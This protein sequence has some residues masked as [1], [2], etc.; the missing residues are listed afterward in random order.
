MAPRYGNHHRGGVLSLASLSES[1]LAWIAVVIGAVSIY[2]YFKKRRPQGGQ[3]NAPRDGQGGQVV[4][5]AARHPVGGRAASAP[6]ENVRDAILAG[7]GKPW[8][9][10]ITWDVVSSASDGQRALA[11]FLRC[12]ANVILVAR[13]RS[14]AEQCEILATLRPMSD[15]L[16]RH[17][18]LF[19]HSEKAFEAFA[20]QLTPTVLMSGKRE[21]CTLLAR[22][23]PYVVYVF[24]NSSSSGTGEQLVIASNALN[25]STLDAFPWLS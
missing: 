16:P 21:L 19:C 9:L 20:R 13:V 10:Y 5:G 6:V 23:V 3:P 25:I 2:Y 7:R 15:L 4:G 14:E 8:T 22:F 24:G 12:G 11:E 17:K 1:S 18:I